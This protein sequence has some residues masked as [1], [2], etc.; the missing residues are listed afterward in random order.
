MAVETVLEDDRWKQAGLENLA[1]VFVSQTLSHLGLPAAEFEVAVLGCDDA[2]IAGLNSDFRKNA[3]PTNV[4]SWPSE[5][6]ASARDGDVPVPPVETEIGDIAIA[7]DTC[8]REATEQDKA[9]PDHVGHLLVHATLHLLGYDHT[10]P[11][12]ALLMESLEVAILAS[13]GIEDPY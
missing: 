3:R 11:K 1:N 12:D 6:L 10:R 2:R 13:M 9:F 8:L 4:L 5:S 7:F